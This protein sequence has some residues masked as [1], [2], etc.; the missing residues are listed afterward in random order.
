MKLGEMQ[1]SKPYTFLQ[2][3]VF[4]GIWPFN[5]LKAPINVLFLTLLYFIAGLAIYFYYKLPDYFLFAGS[6]A[7]ISI[8]LWTL[9]IFSYADRLRN[10]DIEDLNLTNK[11]FLVQ[12]MEDL[13]HPSSIVF[14][15]VLTAITYVFLQTA[16]LL[17]SQSIIRLL[18][19]ELDVEYLPP[20]ILLYIFLITFDVCYRLG[21]SAYFM[22]MQ[23]R[24]NL[25]LANYLNNKNLRKNFSPFDIKKLEKADFYHYTAL[26]AGLFLYPLVSYDLYLFIGLSLYLVMAF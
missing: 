12:Y 6:F 1:P 3:Y 14:G 19:D 17:G 8:T 15:V 24:R 9:G 4:Q 5:R 22:I 2:E 10:V 21:L 13:F 7:A 11:K 23:F 18:E 26:L 20:V 16:P 25:R